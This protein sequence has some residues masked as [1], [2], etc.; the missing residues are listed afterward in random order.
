MGADVADGL[1]CVC[2]VLIKELILGELI[3]KYDLDSR[4]LIV[5]G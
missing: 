1:R 3:C 5:E 2:S 4:T